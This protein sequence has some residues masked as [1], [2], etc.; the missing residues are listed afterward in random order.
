MNPSYMLYVPISHLVS[1]FITIKHD[2]RN[3]KCTLK[4][5]WILIR[6]KVNSDQEV[7]VQS[8]NIVYTKEFLNIKESISVQKQFTN[9]L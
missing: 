6:G 3:E 1:S 7:R 4:N 5:H 2:L 9:T 8:D